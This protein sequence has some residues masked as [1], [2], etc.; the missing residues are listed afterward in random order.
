M[1][2]S[3]AFLIVI[4]G[5]DANG[6]GG[7]A[8]PV[9]MMPLP[10]LGDMETPPPLPPFMFSPPPYPPPFMP[11]PLPPHPMGRPPPLGRMSSP[12]PPLGQFSPPPPPYDRMDRSSRS[13]SPPPHRYHHRSPPPPDQWGAPVGATFR[14]V[15]KPSP[16]KPSEQ[17]DPRGAAFHLFVPACAWCMALIVFAIVN[18]TSLLQ[19]F[20]SDHFLFSGE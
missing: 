16:K 4:A 2:C 11:P 17:R 15:P 19:I 12:P 13:P 10:P 14:P 5:L 8:S 1:S 7:V 9:M 18:Q 3:N 6:E 20:L